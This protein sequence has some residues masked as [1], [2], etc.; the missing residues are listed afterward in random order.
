MTLAKTHSLKSWPNF[1]E[2]IRE[3]VKTFEIRRDDRDFQI[4]D[5]LQLQE[6]DMS[7]ELYSGNFLTMRISYLLRSPHFGLQDGYVAIGIVPYKSTVRSVMTSKH[8]RVK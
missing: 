4:G 3:G 6:Y 5:L 7:R 1:F 2:K 8:R